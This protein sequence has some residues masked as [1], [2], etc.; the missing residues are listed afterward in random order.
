MFVLGVWYG[1]GTNGTGILLSAK[2][3][4]SNSEPGQQQQ[5]IWR[6]PASH[7][8]WKNCKSPQYLPQL[9]TQVQILHKSDEEV[10][11]RIARPGQTFGTGTHELRRGKEHD[12]AMPVFAFNVRR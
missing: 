1:F 3:R 6:S 5:T 4:H 11:I 10:A 9:A 12:G 8:D 2:T 7:C